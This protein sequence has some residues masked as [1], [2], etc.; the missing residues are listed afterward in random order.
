M[1][2][3]I[4][5][6]G[7]AVAISVVFASGI[8]AKEYI[9]TPLNWEGHLAKF[10]GRIEKVDPT[11]KE[12]T[13]QSGK[14]TMTFLTDEKTIA[15]DWTQKVPFSGL[16]EGMWATVE[17]SHQRGQMFARWIDVANSG[18]QLQQRAEG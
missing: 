18:D 4:W 3:T 11:M 7:L 2:K 10:T 13:V 16:K 8:M 15:S 14:Q 17:Y 9:S 5:M 6:M 1:K 12:V